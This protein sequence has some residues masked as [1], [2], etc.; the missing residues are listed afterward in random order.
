MVPKNMLNDSFFYKR[1]KGKN[2][3]H[4]NEY[5]EPVHVKFVKI[6]RKKRYYRDSQESAVKSN[7][8]IF[9]YQQHTEPFLEF[10]EQ[11][12]VIIDGQEY[13]LADANKHKDP[14]SSQSSIFELGV[15]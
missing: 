6:E 13:V 8:R 12:Q 9:C 3:S 1:F 11:S 10:E 2:R 5:D 14:F 15:L 7:A 4:V